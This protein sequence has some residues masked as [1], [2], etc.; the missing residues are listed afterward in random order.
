MSN[1]QLPGHPEFIPLEVIRDDKTGKVKESKGE[2]Y[3][4][5]SELEAYQALGEKYNF[6]IKKA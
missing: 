5:E 2:A 6:T 1:I 4:E 3:I